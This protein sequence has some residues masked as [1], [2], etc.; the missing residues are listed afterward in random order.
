MYSQHFYTLFF[1]T[2]AESNMEEIPLSGVDPN[3]FIE[4]MKVIHPPH[5]AVTVHN[6]DYLLKVIDRSAAVVQ[7][8]C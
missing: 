6:V 2:F 5:A 8:S 3:E 4:V 1:G 7:F